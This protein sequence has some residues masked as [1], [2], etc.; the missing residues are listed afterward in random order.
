MVILAEPV[1]YDVCIVGAGPAGLAALSACVEPYSLDLLGGKQGLRAAHA[2]GLQQKKAAGFRAPRVCVVDTETWL[3]TWR[4]RFQHV[5]IEWLRSPTLA[6]P[7]AFDSSAMLCFAGENERTHELLDSG[8][9]DKK[10]LQLDQGS[11]SW[12][13]PSNKLFLDFCDD[14]V[15]RSPHEFVKGRANSIQGEDGD[16]TVGLEDGR[17]LRSAAIV[18]AL[19]VPGPP[20]IPASIAKLPSHLMFHSDFESGKRLEELGQGRAKRILVLGGGLTAVQVALLG[21][22][23]KCK[24]TLCSRRPLTSRHFDIDNGWFDSRESARHRFGFLNIPLEERLAMIKQ[25]RGGGTV[26]PFYMDQLRRAE[27]AGSLKVTVSEVQ[28]SKVL[29]NE[30]DVEFDGAI[31]RFDLV[32]SACGHR[33][34]CTQLPLVHA[35]L[36]DSPVQISGGLPHLSQ[37]LQW[38]E[39]KKLF[40][41]GSLA[42]LQVGPDAGNLMGIR[43]ACQALPTSMG[44]RDWLQQEYLQIDANS[45]QRNVRGNSYAILQDDDGE[46]ESDSEEESLKEESDETPKIDLMTQ[47]G[48][49]STKRRLGKRRGRQKAPRPSRKRG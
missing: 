11:R 46:S 48:L 28:V 5:N 14:L 30:V 34:D 16:F 41:V 38:G 22:K 18:L 45:L 31:A 32:V 27:S 9:V 2:L 3:T 4:Q 23:R 1:D 13:L 12:H 49:T 44:L 29:D 24:V 26:P 8:C 35:L 15:S 10:L 43:R 19:G 17:E 37:D 7:D 36:K 40:V 6:H 42:S 47:N 25:T 20:V 39:H 21:V 33:P